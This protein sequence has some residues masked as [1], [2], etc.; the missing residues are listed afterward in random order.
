M[1]HYDANEIVENIERV[2]DE[3]EAESNG[4]SDAARK[5]LFREERAR[6][7][8]NSLFLR[9]EAGP[10]PAMRRHQAIDKVPGGARLGL[11]KRIFARLLRIIS[12]PQSTY[13]SQNLDALQMMAR[14]IDTLRERIKHLEDGPARPFGASDLRSAESARMDNIVRQHL[15]YVQ[16]NIDQITENIRG[17]SM[18]LTQVV[19]NVSMVS[20]RLNSMKVGHKDL[21]TDIASAKLDVSRLWTELGLVYE[22]LDKRAEDIWEG[23]EQRD[24]QLVTNTEA[25][26][27]LHGQVGSLESAS[28]ELKARLL[29]LNEQLTMQQEMLDQVSLQMAQRPVETD[30]EPS[31]RK[32]SPAVRGDSEAKERVSIQRSP[33]K[34]TT[35][36]NALLQRQLDL[37]Y[38]RFQRQYRGDEEELRRRQREYIRLLNEHLEHPEDRQPRLLDVACGDGIFVELLLENDW[39]A[40][41]VDLNE[42]MVKH[43]TSRNLKITNADALAFLDTCEAKQFDAISMFQF[44]EH[45]PPSE[46]LRLLKNTWRALKPGGLVL[47]ETINPHTIMALHWFH[48]DL[49]HQRLIFPEMMELLA[50]TAGFRTIE[51]KGLNPVSQDEKLR[52]EGSEVEREN[53]HRLNRLLFGDQDYYYLGRKPGGSKEDG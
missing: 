25:T 35:E 8:K 20:G 53:I 7:R 49:T 29:V 5:S 31:Q 38:L 26:Q 34:I 6:A 11:V 23:L 24:T 4:L 2:L 32:P 15:H 12:A 44:V 1:A 10:L 17:I 50:E 45:L 36:S 47:V 16:S 40:E 33:A 42:S 9:L 3:R 39:E 19:D 21:S 52:A 37:A 46:L 13:N 43:G 14:E 30:A 28:R 27:K 48:L 51:W 22:S 41:G 18:A